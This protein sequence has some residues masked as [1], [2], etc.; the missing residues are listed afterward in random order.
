MTA[1]S[2][3]TGHHVVAVSDA[4]G[5]TAEL[6]A[7]A[8]LAQFQ[9]AKVEIQRFPNVRSVGDIRRAIELAVATKGIVI[10]T[11]VSDELRRAALREGKRRNVVTIDLMGPLLLRLS[12]LL[13]VPPLIQP[14]L[15][16]QLRVGSLFQMEAVEYCVKHD[17]GQNPLGLD[18]ADIVLVGV[19]RTS[20]TPLSLYLS[21]KGWLVANVPVILNL[22]LPGPLMRID[23]SRIV[24]LF[25]SPERLVELRRARLE[26]PDAPLNGAYADLEQVRAEVRYS[27]SLFRKAAWP[28][29]DMTNTS[30]EEA[31]AEVLALVAPRAAT[32]PAQHRQ[33]PARPRRR[34]EASSRG[35]R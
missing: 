2:P 34:Q 18:R 8:A 25:A 6:V 30:I 32:E 21:W 23:Q 15:L 26:H 16:R 10:H 19:S 31:A 20:K 24:G 9:T 28:V 14:G 17:D 27:R 3:L 11:L 7:R 5:G 22:P 29:I 35:D 33:P 13:Q 12:D 4:T 1:S